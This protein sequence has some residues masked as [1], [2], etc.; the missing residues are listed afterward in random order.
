MKQTLIFILFILFPMCMTAQQERESLPV[1]WKAIGQ[2]AKDNPDRIKELVTRLSAQK[3]DTTLTYQERILAFYGQS[4]LT[5]DF[6]DRYR[7]DMDRLEKA[8]KHEEC[9]ATAQ[10]MLEINPLNLNALITSAEMILTMQKDSTKQKNV[11][12]EDAKLYV[13]R[14]MRILNTIAATGDGSEEHPFYVTKVSDEYC[15]MR[16]YLD[17]WNYKMQ[18]ATMCCDVIT[19]DGSSKYYDKPKIYFEITRVYE[20]ERMMF[21]E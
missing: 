14:A 2:E 21:N 18:A 12:I 5:N 7:I 10:K 1:D 15:F 9:L 17:L 19:L 4:F 13:N 16:Y 8:G 3:I 20:L 11:A 6:E